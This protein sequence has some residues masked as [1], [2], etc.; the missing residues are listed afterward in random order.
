[1][2]QGFSHFSGCLHHFV[3]TKLATSSIRVNGLRKMTAITISRRV[4]VHACY[5]RSRHLINPFTLKISSRN[6]VCYFHTFGNNLEIKRKIAKYFKESCCLS[7]D[8]H[9]SFKCFQKKCFCTENIS[10]IVRP[11]LAAL[12]VNGLRVNLILLRECCYFHSII[13]P[14][15]GYSKHHSPHACKGYDSTT[16]SYL[17]Y[18]H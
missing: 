7:S 13:L 8:Q 17:W 18:W 15:P 6:I 9:F 3:L 5:V 4:C 12:S 11:L 16:G 1:M 10:K 2:C 14:M